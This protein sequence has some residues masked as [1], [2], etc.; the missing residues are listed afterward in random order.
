MTKGGDMDEVEFMRAYNNAR[1]LI[2]HAQTADGEQLKVH[3]TNALLTLLAM[4]DSLNQ[5]L[6]EI[7]END[8]E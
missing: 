7:A 3:L 6:D 1:L 2:A 8:D 4:V 5:R